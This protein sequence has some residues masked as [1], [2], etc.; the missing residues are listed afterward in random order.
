MTRTNIRVFRAWP[1]KPAL[2]I[3]DKHY[4]YTGNRLLLAEILAHVKRIDPRAADL[5]EVRP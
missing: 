5:P 2:F 1:D 4:S 3:P